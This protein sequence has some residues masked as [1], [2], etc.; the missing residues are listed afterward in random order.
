MLQY[1][2]IYQS[3]KAA[4]TH[5]GYNFKLRRPIM[6]SSLK[7]FAIGSCELLIVI[8]SHVIVNSMD[9]LKQVTS[10]TLKNWVEKRTA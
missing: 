4:M 3:E 2:A 8:P 10:I 5:L 6:S 1:S 9:G 7:V